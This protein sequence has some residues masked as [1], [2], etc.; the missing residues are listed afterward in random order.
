MI[1][2][3]SVNHNS[4]KFT[5]ENVDRERTRNNIDYCNRDIKEI[6]HELFDEAEKRFNDRQKRADRR[7]DDYY[8][9]ICNSK[10]EKPF[11]E[12][13]IQIGNSE[14]MSALDENGALAKT[15]LDRYYG[16]FQKRNP[17]L[18]VFSAH[19]HMDEATPHLHIDFVP[20]TTD[21]KRGLDTR[22]SLKQALANQGFKSTGRND[23]E[24]N[25]WVLAEK[26]ELEFVMQMYG[27]EWEHKGTHEEH[28]SVLNF[29]KQERL[30]ELSA[31]DDK[32]IDRKSELYSLGQRIESKEK[33]II[34][35]EEVDEILDSEDY[36][37][38]EPP[39]MM[40]AKTYKARFVDPLIKKLKELVRKVLQKSFEGWDNYY[41][42]SQENKSR[43]RENAS[44]KADN[45]RLYKEYNRL[46]KGVEEYALLQKAFGYKKID[47]MVRQARDAQNT[48]NAKHYKDFYER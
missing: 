20:F 28:L 22:V 5:A 44:L 3:G 23:T 8:E 9:K 30:K 39:T 41:K 16:A 13:I 40:T 21:S 11:K 47:S 18:R 31:L 48:R 42:A 4:R 29:K 46:Y 25:Q 10:Q 12:I 33:E 26:K 45:D 2:K 1:G 35:L 15:I 24:W 37:L 34:E 36:Q 43:S 7:I 38:P 14:D 19:L 27:V 32:I 17:Y 6:Y